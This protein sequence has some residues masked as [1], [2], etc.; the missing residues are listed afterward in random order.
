[1]PA[2]S[3]LRSPCP[4]AGAL[5]ILGDRW[6]L[7]VMRDALFYGKRRYAD[8]LA[9]PEGIASNILAER[10]ARLERAGLIERR[11]YEERPPREEYHPTAR[12]R[13]IEPVLRE[14]ITWGKCHVAGTAKRPP[15]GA[16]LRTL[17]PSSTGQG[18]RGETSVGGSASAGTT[19]RA[20]RRRR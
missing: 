13:D 17:L 18:R 3:P 12:G 14:L 20:T 5:D 19:R 11:R 10:L 16:L 4:I 15:T 7:L 2:R 6:T 9:S 1:M 8:F